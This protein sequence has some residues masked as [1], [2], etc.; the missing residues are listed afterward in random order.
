[1]NA[2]VRLQWVIKG[3]NM[4]EKPQDDIMAYARSKRKGTRRMYKFGYEELGQTVG[5]NSV[6]CRRWL[7]KRGLSLDKDKPMENL[8]IAGYYMQKMS[9]GLSGRGIS[10]VASPAVA[11]PK[12]NAVSDTETGEV[13]TRDAPTG[14]SPALAKMEAILRNGPP[15]A[16]TDGRSQMA[17]KYDRYQE[18][19]M[20]GAHM[21]EYDDYSQDEVNEM[22]TLKAWLQSHGKAVA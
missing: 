1:L 15:K 22:K 20:Q 21:S 16:K 17:T 4:S 19:Y 2:K 3:E 10:L 7:K 8:K 13:Y 11:P 6:A 18:L 12:F 9:N 5:S 14:V